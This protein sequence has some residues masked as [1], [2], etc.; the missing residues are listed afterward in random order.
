MEIDIHQ[1]SVPRPGEPARAHRDDARPPAPG[2]AR[3]RPRG[4]HHLRGRTGRAHH[5]ALH[6]VQ[7]RF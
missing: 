7:V 6:R 2:A 1:P 5:G 4:V 3:A